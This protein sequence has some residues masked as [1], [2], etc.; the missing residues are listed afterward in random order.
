MRVLS[1]IHQRDAATG[2]FADVIDD[3]EEASFALGEPP[4]RDGY[5]ATIVFGGSMN[6]VEEDEHPWLREEKEFIRA[7]VDNGHPVLGVCLGSQLL[8]EVA[9]AT[10][11]RLPRAEIGWH[12]VELVG[13][14]PV[15]G[16]LPRRFSALEWHGYGSELPPGALELARSSAG[17]QAFRLD[18]QP[19]WGIQ[20]H[21]EV[22]NRD[23]E[24]WIAEEDRPDPALAG[25]PER[26]GAWNELGRSLC[27]AFLREAAT[28]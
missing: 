1:L 10:V 14:D 23:L 11:D 15:L 27:R 6:V 17:L 21:A 24:K 28:R 13:N 19:A 22:T 16:V 20:F 9:G 12:D 18:R 4:S 3:L 5:D 26:I 2:V 25:T 8:A 7:L